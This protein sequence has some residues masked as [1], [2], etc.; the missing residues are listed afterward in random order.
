M[1]SFYPKGFMSSGKRLVTTTG[2]RSPSVVPDIRH[3]ALYAGE[4]RRFAKDFP[5]PPRSTNKGRT[6]GDQRRLT[7]N[8]NS[9]VYLEEEF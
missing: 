6:G 7:T 3:A 8:R 1:V 4:A 9:L 5:G 2:S